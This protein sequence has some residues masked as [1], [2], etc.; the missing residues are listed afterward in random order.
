MRTRIRHLFVLALPVVLGLQ[1][2]GQEASEPFQR[3]ATLT[4]PERLAELEQ[5]IPALMDSGGIT[6]LAMAIVSDSAIEWSRGFG[7]KSSETGE[8]V[9]ENSVFEAA[10]LS[11]PVFAYAVL[12]LVDQGIIDLDT[13]IADYYDYEVTEDERHKRITP[14]MVLS[15][16][17]GFPNW[18]PREGQLTIDFD[19]GTEFRYSGE[20]FGYLQLA[21]MDVTDETLQELT[22]R[23]VFEPLGM[24]NSSYIW[25]DRFEEN[26]ALPHGTHS[27]VLEKRRP[28]RGH[29]AASLHTTAVDFAR[30]MIAVMNGSGLSDSTAV[31]MLTPQV[32]VDTGVTWGLGI[33]IQ[34]NEA[35]RALWHW[36]DN[37]A[38][39]AYTL[40][41]PEH[42]VGVVW[43]T[44]SENGQ[45]ILES[46][47]AHTVGSAHPAA[48]WLDYE[49]HDSPKRQVRE[50]LA[51]TIDEQ[52][53]DAAIALYREMK[54]TQPPEAFDEYV[55]NTL[56]YRLL[57]SDRV[58]EAIAIFLLNVEEYPD[59][60]NPYDS[61]GEAYAE[62]GE[63]E[64]AIANY[65]KSVEL[66]PE[67]TNG[68]AALQ[69]LRARLAER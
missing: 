10:S 69:R 27:E 14:R 35:G 9:D 8:P 54:E 7:V 13:P 67:N 50:T 31:A 60:S 45:T 24:T 49:Q 20:G 5:V 16:T 18:R 17:T 39:K 59:A 64:L 68:I 37:V 2:C 32:Q 40:T 26:L 66:D 25:D 46:M 22:E 57:R 47:L 65:E 15:H 52:G 62:A 53:V 19:P 30:F 58:Q 28:R 42:G 34:D 51:A 4:S 6:G 23:L 36:G 11:K 12:Q 55:L 61:L 63:L 21:V 1:A 44:N 48:A 43:F 56:G 38:Y 33:G 3:L 29:A 41:F